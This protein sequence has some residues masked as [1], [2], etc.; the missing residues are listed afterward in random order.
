MPSAMGD[1]RLIV[2]RLPPR[3]ISRPR[4]LAELDRVTD[5][6]LTLL[7]AGPGSGKTVLLSDG[8]RHTGARVAWLTPTAADADPPRFWQLLAASLY[9]VAGID[10]GPPGA[11]PQTGTFDL[12][13]A[14]L[15]SV[16]DQAPQLVVVIDDA[17]VLNR[18]EVMED[19]DRLIRGARSLR[20]ILSARSDPL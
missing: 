20:F 5:T 12:V 3:H 16:P 19:L 11:M 9:P 2:P 7:S 14:L 8:V 1:S 15:S 4:L 17:H 13:Q 6:P 18:Q 10:P